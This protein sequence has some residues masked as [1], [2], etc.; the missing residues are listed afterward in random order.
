VA[1]NGRF[2]LHWPPQN[3]SQR[4]GPDEG[5]RAWQL[6]WLDVQT[7]LEQQIAWPQLPGRETA[8]PV[9]DWSPL[10]D[11]FLLLTDNTLLLVEAAGDQSGYVLP[12]A[13]HLESNYHCF[14]AVWM[15]TADSTTD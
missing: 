12:L 4:G 7:G 14:D 13:E 6:Q 10:E 1:P 2:L 5:G 3:V 15:K 9:Y 8:V 11:W